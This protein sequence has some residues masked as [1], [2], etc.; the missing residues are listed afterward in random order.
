M[1]L[2]YHEPQTVISSFK[3]II[4]HMQS[5]EV[6]GLRFQNPHL[7]HNSS[8]ALIFAP[9]EFTCTSPLLLTSHSNGK[10]H[11]IF[12]E[13][14]CYRLDVETFLTFPKELNCRQAWLMCIFNRIPHNFKLKLLAYS[15]RFA[16]DSFSILGQ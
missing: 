13:M 14:C 7:F 11:T 9:S 12:A 2:T 3:C 8:N 10:K 1:E 16:L 6:K 4:A 15:A 5:W